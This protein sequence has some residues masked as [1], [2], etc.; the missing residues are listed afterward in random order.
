MTYNYLSLWCFASTLQKAQSPST[1]PAPAAESLV[2]AISD[3]ILE[4]CAGRKRCR[5]GKQL[6]APFVNPYCNV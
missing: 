5:A 1:V 6:E 2:L 4:G 3:L